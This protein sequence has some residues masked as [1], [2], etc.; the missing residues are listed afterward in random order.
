M[1]SFTTAH[2]AAS[3]AV[4]YESRATCRA[5]SAVATAP[6]ASSRAA[7]VLARYSTLDWRI[8]RRRRTVPNLLVKQT[9]YLFCRVLQVLIVQHTNAFWLSLPF[10]SRRSIKVI[11]GTM[12]SSIPS[13][14]MVES[15]IKA[16]VVM[17]TFQQ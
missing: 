15:E 12:N 11:L 10:R 4:H 6:S 13:P 3:F 8:E 5:L 1:H 7:G 2:R 16:T 9:K 17:K 14:K